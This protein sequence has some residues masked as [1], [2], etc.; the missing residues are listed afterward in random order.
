MELSGGNRRAWGAR[1]SH[2]HQ[3]GGDSTGGGGRGGGS[4][5]SSAVGGGGVGGSYAEDEVRAAERL[6]ISV[7]EVS[8]TVDTTKEETIRVPREGISKVAQSVESSDC[9]L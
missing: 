4:R 5:E 7:R 9:T 3:G 1:G 6:G 8:M 2:G